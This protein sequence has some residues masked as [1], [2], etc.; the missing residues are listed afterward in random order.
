MG[1]VVVERVLLVGVVLEVEWEDLGG[2]FP[3]GGVNECKEEEVSRL[4]VFRGDVFSG[5]LLFE[6][7]PFFLP[8]PL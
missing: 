8:P 7:F 4:E 3:L 5:L 2:E 1:V 6:P